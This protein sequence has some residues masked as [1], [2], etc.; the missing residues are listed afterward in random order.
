MKDRSSDLDDEIMI[1]SAQIRIQ[2]IDYNLSL[3]YNLWLIV[4]YD[5]VRIKKFSLTNQKFNFRFWNNNVYS[6][7]FNQLGWPV[8]DSEAAWGELMGPLKIFL[9]T[10]RE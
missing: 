10:V 8:D 2:L 1:I 9:T 4:L 3:I 5:L 6:Q 7:L